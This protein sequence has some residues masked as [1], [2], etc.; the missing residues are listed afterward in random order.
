MKIQ[1]S[2]T[3]LGEVTLPYA[4]GLIDEEVREQIAKQWYENDVGIECANDIEW[5]VI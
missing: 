4:C 3:F 2:I 5:E 1:Y